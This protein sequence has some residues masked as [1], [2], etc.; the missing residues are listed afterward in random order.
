MYPPQFTAALGAHERTLA[1]AM[2]RQYFTTLGIPHG[3]TIVDIR[4]QL[5]TTQG[6]DTAPIWRSWIGLLLVNSTP[7]P[8]APPP[9]HHALAPVDRTP[10]RTERDVGN[11]RPSRTVAAG[12]TRGRAGGRTRLWEPGTQIS[13][14]F[15]QDDSTGAFTNRRHHLRNALNLYERYANLTFVEKTPAEVQQLAI[16]DMFI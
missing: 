16:V 7:L 8:I 11:V 13:Y 3:P 5:E 14:F 15:Q 9:P 12:P 2:M 4:N 1:V 10:D 6:D